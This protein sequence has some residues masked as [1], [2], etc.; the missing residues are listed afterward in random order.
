MKKFLLI[1][2]ITT[3]AIAQNANRKFENFK[4]A[5]NTLE[6][7][8]SDGKYIF[9]SYSDKIIETSF[10]PKGETFDATSHAV[11]LTP[12]SGIAKVK[13]DKNAIQFVT[14]GIAVTIQKSPFKI[15]YS[16]KSKALIS[17]KNGYFKKDSTDVID[18]N[19]DGSEILYGGGA[20]ALGMNRRGNRLQLY[21]R[22]HYGYETKAELMN[23]CIPLVLSSKI[24]AVHFDNEPIG[25]LDL[26]S[27]KDNTLAYETISGRKTYQ[28]IAAD[29]WPDLIGSY[30]DLTG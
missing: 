21:N 23:F 20:R 22:A 27:K 14:S 17:E 24:Y 18:F 5:N 2:F 11:I 15:S 10:I 30:T 3:I 16:Y 7:T 13:S 4:K 1:F 26:D 28:V 6:V 29:S 9:K 25:Y 12:K 19:L 8:T